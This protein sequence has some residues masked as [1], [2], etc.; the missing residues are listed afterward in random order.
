MRGDTPQNKLCNYAMYSIRIIYTIHQVYEYGFFK[1]RMGKLH[2]TKQ[3]YGSQDHAYEGI[4][5]KEHL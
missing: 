4:G 2:I 1:C 3:M 5:A